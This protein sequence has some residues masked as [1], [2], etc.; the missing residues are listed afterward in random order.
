[1]SEHEDYDDW[2]P[3]KLACSLIRPARGR[4]THLSTL[5]RW[6]LAGRLEFRKR[7]RWLFVRRSEVLA[8]TG[9][10]KRHRAP[11]PAPSRREN[12]EFTRKT[13]EK[14]GLWRPNL[15]GTV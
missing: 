9:E 13:L 11:C 6:V 4:K 8:M 12:D 15:R 1:M 10:A 3:A 5:Y 7:G 2:I 14:F